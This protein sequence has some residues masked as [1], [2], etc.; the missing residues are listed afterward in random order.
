MVDAYDSGLAERLSVAE[1]WAL[2]LVMAGQPLWS[3]GG[4]IACLDDERAARGYASGMIAEV[5]WALQIIDN[6]GPWQEAM[7]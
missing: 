7:V 4:W 5:D 2:P 3:L 6:L 1:R